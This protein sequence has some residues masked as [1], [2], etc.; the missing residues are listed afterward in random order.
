MTG[1]SAQ[2][3]RRK[4]YRRYNVVRTYSADGVDGEPVKK[5][6][7]E[8]DHHVVFRL[9]TPNTTPNEISAAVVSVSSSARSS[10]VEDGS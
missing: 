1:E 2:T 4:I 5:N 3:P 9:I 6:T 10:M 7:E 8:L